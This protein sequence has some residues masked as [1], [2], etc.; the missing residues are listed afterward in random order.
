[1]APQSTM[2]KALVGAGAALDDLRGDELLARAALALDEHVDVARRDLLEVGEEL[3]HRH[4]RAREGA[5]RAR[6]VAVGH[7][8]LDRGLE[9]ARGEE[10][11]AEREGP[12]ALQV[13]VANAHA[14]D[15][16]AVERP[17]VL[18]A[19]A[20]PVARELAVKA[21]DGRIEEDHVVAGVRPDP[22]DGP[23]VDDHSGLA[24]GLAAYFERQLGDD[25]DG[26]AHG[27]RPRVA[28]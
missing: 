24:A 21:R 20:G 13:G 14:V 6:R 23:L 8:L 5:E 12:L 25:G 9:P 28:A 18:H 1:M 2:T 7:V 3:A 26:A 11:V 17:A 19:P 22:A 10:A 15:L 4:A 27:P 16:R